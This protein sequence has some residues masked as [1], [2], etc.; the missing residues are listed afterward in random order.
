MGQVHVADALQDRALDPV[1]APDTSAFRVILVGDAGAPET[2][3]RDPLLATLRWHAEAAGPN[4]AV[5][6]LGDN[7]YPDGLPPE[8]EPDRAEAESRLRAQVDAVAGLPGRAVF[9]PGNHDWKHSQPGGLEQLRRQEAYVEEA[10]GEGSFL[11]SNGFPGPV[12]VNLTD[13]LRLLAIDTEWWLGLHDR[14]EGD[15]PEAEASVGTD[16]DF[17]LALSREVERAGDRRLLVVGHHPILSEG[18][19]SGA[20]PPERHLFP[21]LA[22]HPRA[23]VPLPFVGSLAVAMKRFRGEDHQDLGHARYR[24]LREALI[25]IFAPAEGLIYAAGHDHS[26][27]YL[28]AIGSRRAVRQVISGSGSKVSYV[29][30]RD[31]LFAASTQ[32]FVV[33]TYHADGSA[34]MEAIRPAEGRPEGETLVRASLLPPFPDADGP[35]VVDGPPPTLP[36]TGTA[37]ASL[38]YAEAGPVLRTLIGRGYRDTWATPV[39]APVLDLGTEAGGVVPIR[40]GGDRQ[41]RSLWLEAENG[42]VLK[43]RSIEK[44]PANPFGLGLTFGKP[45]EWAQDVTSGAY[46]YAAP[47]AAR[48]SDAAGLYHTNPRVVY[49]PDDPRLGPYRE[50]FRDRLMMLE[51]HPDGPADGRPHFGGAED[52]VGPSKLRRELDGDADHRVDARFFLRARLFDMLIGDWDRHRDQ[53]RWAAFEPGDLDPSLTG[54][55][56]TK[57]KVYRPV[58]RDRDFAFNDRSGLLFD[59]ARPHLPKLQGL[60]TRYGNVEGLTRSGRTQDRRFLAPLGRDAYQREAADLQATLTDSVLRAALDALPAEV[61][62]RDRERLLDALRARRDA[63]GEAAMTYFELLNGTLDVVGSHDDEIVDLAWLDGDRLQIRLSKRTKGDE[64]DFLLWE[65]T[66]TPDDETQEVRIWARG[67]EDRVTVTGQRGS[68]APH[69]RVLT[70][71]DED[72]LDDQTDGRGLSVYDGRAPE[73]LRVEAAGPEARVDRTNRVATS[74]FGYTP[75]REMSRLPLV[76]LGLNGDDGLVIGGG[77]DITNPGFGRERFLRRHQITGAVA[78]ATGGVAGRYRGTYPD[79]LGP[80]DLG[81]R[82]EA[83]T[84]MSALNFF[85]F[86]DGTSPEGLSPDSFRVRLARVEVEPWLQRELPGSLRAWVGPSAR[87]AYGD[88]PATAGV[89]ARDLD[90]QLLVGLVAGLDV[91]AVDRPDRPTQGGRF[92]LGARALSSVLDADHAYVGLGTSLT[93]YATHPSLTWATLAVR[94]GGEHLV[95]TFPFYDAAT[96]GGPRSLR[97]YRA[98]RFTGRSSVF[99]SAEPRV[100]LSRF[101]MVVTGMAE[102]GLLAFA[103]VGRVWADSAPASWHLGTGGG[104]WLSLPGLTN[105]TATYEASDEYGQVAVRMGFAL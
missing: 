76:V 19:H 41:S 74:A 69:V 28:E 84:P 45:H 42:R 49:V 16:D 85:G 43:L 71:A 55:A 2:D 63:L 58:A 44:H 89:P 10:L 35:T 1:A 6:F 33:L 11:P 5:V 92:T 83:R 34:D 101:P 99:A 14:G 50:T 30:P 65:R 57:G 18:D 97:G 51:D 25:E 52:L 7:I 32:G 70:G 98:E 4:S 82:A 95:G 26:L 15:D 103:D 9:I 64:P 96:V 3:E 80:H 86:G 13:D 62:D 54:D 77:V 87:Y 100:L 93:L 47:I 12:R 8:G 61:R 24:A 66:L 90:G 21:L 40:T 46:P 27:Q 23:Y 48:L 104:L 60:Q 37:A 36:A 88:A 72:I 53:W 38:R 56:A 31:A 94:G 39:E 102:V 68:G 22:L 75:A 20:V 79:A 81:L 59:L 17:L 105:L 67:G 78:T 73:G 29:L 91:D